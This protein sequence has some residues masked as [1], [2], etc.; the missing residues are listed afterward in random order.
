MEMSILM[1]EFRKW[2]DKAVEDARVKLE[3]SSEQISHVLFI[4]LRELEDK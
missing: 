2:L 4:K 3:L 1:L